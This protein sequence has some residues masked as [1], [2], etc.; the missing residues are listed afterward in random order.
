MNP[1]QFEKIKIL[2]AVFAGPFVLAMG[3]L[4]LVGLPIAINS[5]TMYFK[6]N[7]P[8][9]LKDL[10]MLLWGVAGILGV[11]GFWWGA[12]SSQN[13]S[14]FKALTIIGFIL[15]GVLASSPILI[16]T[17]SLNWYFFGILFAPICSLILIVVLFKTNQSLRFLKN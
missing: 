4:D 10:L 13:L 9:N 11:I 1:T 17:Y 12:L 5:I 7:Q 16:I 15:S 14:K 8:Y 3:A 2:L 6:K